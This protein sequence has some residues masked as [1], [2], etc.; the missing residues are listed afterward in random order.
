[1]KISK[2]IIILLETDE[3]FILTNIFTK[4]SI[5][6][7]IDGL[8]FFNSLKSYPLKKILEENR[9]NKFNIYFIQ[10]FTNYD[11]LLADPTRLK[12]NFKSI[13][14]KLISAE[15]LIIELKNHFIIIDDEK[16]YS[17]YFKLKNSLLDVEHMGNFHQQLGQFLMVNKR[18]DPSNW[19]LNQKFNLADYKLKNNLY[20]AIQGNFLNS[21]FENKFSSNDVVLDIGCGPGFYSNMIGK[22]GAKVLGVDPNEKY[23][24]IARKNSKPNTT[25][26]IK[27]IGEKGGLDS[28]NDS[29]VDYIF[30]SD[31]LLFYFV[32]FSNEKPNIEI[33]FNDIKRI[34]KP[35]GMFISLEPHYIFW[36]LPWL[37]E[38]KNPYTVLTEY[39][40]NFF[41][42]TPTI[43]KL[44]QTYRKGGFSVHW[45]EELYPDKSFEKIDSRA[46]YFAS[47]FPLWHLFELK[48]V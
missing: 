38:I 5:G 36:L 48:S 41:G 19:W 7:D 2:D 22:T 27:R 11:G 25:F 3:F 43:S 10:D 24:E 15:E 23:V 39:S 32:P 21:Y 35:N 6:L 47:K 1:M 29:S 14:S 13:N 37:G 12:R 8:I 16:N 33:L 45:M 26:D 30:M 34:L 42:V 31:A 18:E 4:T 44:I 20:S 9:N 40:K 28:I 46:Y 17:N